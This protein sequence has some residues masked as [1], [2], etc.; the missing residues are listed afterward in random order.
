MA[1]TLARSQSSI[2]LINFLKCGLQVW[3]I[4]A[5]KYICNLAQSWFQSASE[6]WLVTV[7]MLELSLPLSLLLDTLHP[8]HCVHL[9]L[10]QSRPPCSHDYGLQLVLHTSTIISSKSIS[11]LAR[12]ELACVSLSSVYRNLPVHPSVH[13]HMACIQVNLPTC[14]IIAIITVWIFSQLWSPGAPPMSIGC[15]LQP[16]WLSVYM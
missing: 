4:M 3:N 13:T 8:D 1:A 6:H 14:S 7:S 5:S 2:A 11:K 12:T 16:G 15:S 10:A 9:Q